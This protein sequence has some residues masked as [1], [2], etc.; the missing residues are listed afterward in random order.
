[1][2]KRLKNCKQ[3]LLDN[4]DKS[5]A[6]LLAENPSLAIPPPK[7]VSTKKKVLIFLKNIQQ[8]YHFD[9]LF[10]VACPECGKQLPPNTLKRHIAKHKKT[11]E[12]PKAPGTP[13]QVWT[14]LQYLQLHIH[15]QGLADERIPCSQCE[16]MLPKN[17]MK[18]HLMKHETA[19][20]VQISRQQLISTT[21]F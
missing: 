6:K 18:R 10:Q 20:Q 9:S 14:S 12:Q 17:A 8:I 2:Q 19:G 15:F 11:K 21:N 7:P 4:D 16:K 13:D 1:M 5:Q 3:K